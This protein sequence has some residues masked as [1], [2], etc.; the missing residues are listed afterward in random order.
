MAQPKNAAT[1][2][3]KSSKAASKGAVS[4]PASTPSAAKTGHA[5]AAPEVE[6]EWNPSKTAL[7]I[8]R[9]RARWPSL[10][11]E[12]VGDLDSLSNDTERVALGARTKAKAVAGDAGR[13]AASLD[14]QLGQYELLKEHYHP[15]R[16]SYY[17]LRLDALVAQIAKESGR[18]TS[19]GD[20]RSG[21]ATALDTAKKARDRL[22][23]AVAK[24]SGKRAA[25]A[26]E[27]V[28]QSIRN[29]V[30]DATELRKTRSAFLLEI[31]RLSQACIDEARVAADALAN[32]GADVTEAGTAPKRDSPTVNLLEGWVLEEMKQARDDVDAAREASPVI[33]R[34]VP[35]SA[36]RH[37][38]G[39]HMKKKGATTAAPAT[40]D[41]ADQA[42]K[43]A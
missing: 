30:K 37:V 39:N 17:L 35:G 13:W 29:L 15:K 33:E 9:L 32:A 40:P 20:A 16:F 28:V 26:G 18:G 7:L 22:G 1:S 21:E 41:A 43:P 42:S 2:A 5:A 25:P 12:E 19:T 23:R 6:E 36:T 3:K 24:V 10:S 8:T 14:R 38:L 11:Q 4:N 31:G 34:L 27:D